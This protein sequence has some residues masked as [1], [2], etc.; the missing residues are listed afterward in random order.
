MKNNRS[1]VNETGRSKNIANLQD[2]NSFCTA[3]GDRY[4]PVKEELKISSL[5]TLHENALLKIK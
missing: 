1:F 2:L 5:K 4:N 3:Y